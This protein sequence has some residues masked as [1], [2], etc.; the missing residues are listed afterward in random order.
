MLEVGAIKTTVPR[1]QPVGVEQGMGSDEEVCNNS[2][3]FSACLPVSL[4]RPSGLDGGF[5]TQGAVRH[6]PL[7][8]HLQRPGG[9]GKVRCNFRPNDLAGYKLPFD[10]TGLKG[11]FGTRTERGVA[12]HKIE[13]NTAIDGGDHVA[14]TPLRAAR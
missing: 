2:R 13:D 6:F 1:K 3:S 10:R 4:R 11:L 12:G 9:R 5:E 7:A 8:K 14:I